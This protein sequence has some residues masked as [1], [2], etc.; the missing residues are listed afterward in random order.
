MEYDKEKFKLLIH[1]VVWQVRD[2]DGWGLTKLFKV[3]WFFEARRYA[4]HN[5]IFS[6]AKYQRDEFG[7][8]PKGAY[9]LLSEMEKSGMISVVDTAFHDHKMR[10]P[11]PSQPP[12]PGLLNADQAKELQYWIDYV[13]GKSAS[14]ISEESHDYGWEIV[15]QG[16]D[17]P[18]HAILAERIRDPEG[19][20]LDWAMS[21][22]RELS[23]P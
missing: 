14:E 13:D 5:D 17:L 20:E 21:R 4:L 2:R 12:K 7:P 1:H 15:G 10:R 19:A 16:D 11:V 8:R 3:L 6:G 18:L 9:P 22:A 23:L